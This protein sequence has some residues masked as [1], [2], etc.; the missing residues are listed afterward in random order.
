MGFLE[1]LKRGA[2]VNFRQAG[3]SEDIENL[4]DL[5]Y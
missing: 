2:K 4:L 5:S 3:F 1:M